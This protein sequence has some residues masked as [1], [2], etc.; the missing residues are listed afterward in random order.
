MQPTYFAKRKPS[1][2][3]SCGRPSVVSIMYGMP[4]SK[5]FERAQRGEI[6]IGGCVITGFDPRWQCLVCGAEIYPERLRGEEFP[7][8][9]L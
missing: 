1:K 9:S 6:A 2:C 4:D 8:W 3:P 7:P 5:G